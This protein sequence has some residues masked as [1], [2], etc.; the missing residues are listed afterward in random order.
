[1]QLGRIVQTEQA[2]IHAAAG[3]KFGEYRRQMASGA[4]HTPRCV[5]FRK[6]ANEHALSLP[7]TANDGKPG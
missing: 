7:S 2:T 5:K 4:L 3:R 6:E 1:M